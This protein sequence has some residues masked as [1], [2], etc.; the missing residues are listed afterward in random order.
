MSEDVKFY[1]RI[2]E[3]DAYFNDLKK[4][5]TMT[6]EE[7][8]KMFSKIRNGDSDAFEKVVLSNLKFVV[9]VA[10][11]YR[12]YGVNFADLIAEGN[13]GLMKAV[14]N[15]DETKGIRFI[16]Y[17]VWWVKAYIQEYINN[18]INNCNVCIEQLDYNN[19]DCEY[20]ET[21][22]IINS[23][24]EDD[25]INAQ[26]RLSSLNELM[27][28]LEKREQR[29]LILYFGLYGNKENTLDEI[30]S[31]MNLTKERVRQIKDKALIKMKSNALMSDE[32]DTFYCLR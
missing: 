17:A 2:E 11:R 8:R 18:T 5:K 26:S 3:L 27:E 16:S 13:I 22:S 32:F 21:S 30:G 7:E 28:C 6:R 10:K 1:E 15:F 19:M 4:C 14:K 31:Q 23:E 29:I 12:K 24:F 20:E 9:T 25:M